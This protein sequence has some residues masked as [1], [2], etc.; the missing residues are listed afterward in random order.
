MATRQWTRENID[1]VREYRRRWYA[2]HKKHAM[3]KIVQ[4]KKAMRA[5]ILELKSTLKCGVC[6]ENHISCLEFH[7][8]NPE[9]KEIVIATVISLGWSRKRI[10]REISKCAVLCSNCHRKLH[11][12]EREQ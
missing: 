11:W 8:E 1:K 12:A 5:W 4:R 10:L 7:H 2:R 6:G 9:E 3:A